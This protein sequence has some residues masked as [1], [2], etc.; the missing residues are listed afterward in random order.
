MIPVFAWTITRI[1]SA[2]LIIFCLSSITDAKELITRKEASLP[3]Y[4]S[5]KGVFPGPKVTQLSPD[6]NASPIRSPIRLRL[7]F[8]MRGS[9][10]DIASLK[11]TYLKTPT[12]D[13]TDRIKEYVSAS[14]IDMPDAELPP[15]THRI[16]VEI[17]DID[18][19]PGANEIILRVLN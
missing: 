7:R 13:L 8:E 9:K 17:S 1:G 3:E 2:S 12:I 5:A 19:L 15:G 14:G 16:K 18:G 6:P 4:M 10:I 11:V